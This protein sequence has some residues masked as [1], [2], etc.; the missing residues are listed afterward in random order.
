MKSN[1]KKI[2]YAI[3]VVSMLSSC[4]IYTTYHRPEDVKIQNLTGLT[5]VQESNDTLPAW[6]EFFTDPALQKL[7]EQG[8]KNNS[9]LRTAQLKVTES[10]A[11]LTAARLA[12]LPT[13]SLSPT[14]TLSS[15]N[16]KTPSKVYSLP[17]AAS[18]QLDVFGSLRNAKERSKAVLEQTKN[19]RQAVQAQLIATIANDYYSLLLLD[20]QLKISEKTMENWKQ[21]VET[22]RALMEAGSSNEASVSQAQASY[23]SVCAS[24]ADLKKNIKD[25][26]DSFSALLGD[27]PHNIERNEWNPDQLDVANFTEKGVPLYLL[28]Q[29]PDVKRSEQILAAAF[30]ATNEARSAFYPSLSLSGTAGWTNSSGLGIVNPGKMILTAVG[31]LTQPIF[32][33]GKLVAQYKISKAQQEEA[34]LDFQQTLLNAGTEVNSDLSQMQTAREKQVYYKKQIIALT[35][36]VNSTKLLM[37]NGSTTYL[38]VLT[39]N[40]NLLSA[41]LNDLSNSFD[42]LQ[43]YIL[44]YQALGGGCK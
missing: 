19:Y 44:L 33:G 14:G 22:Y 27:V 11:S 3:S 5:V 38:E 24:V 4:G 21:L 1:M 29:R 43:S 10:Q 32:Q 12:F 40:Q 37:D 25:L 15:F 36:A 41:Q 17:V 35:T 2:L 8:L 26:E 9:D 16:N 7:I 31:S 42:E 13:F 18:W 6:Q 34:K 39:A 28:A 30:Y 20:S 23:L